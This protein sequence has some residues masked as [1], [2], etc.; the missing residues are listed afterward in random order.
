MQGAKCFFAPVSIPHAKS[1]EVKSFFLELFSP[2]DSTSALGQRCANTP[3]RAVHLLHTGAGC[4]PLAGRPSYLE[5]MFPAFV[6]AL[7]PEIRSHG[8]KQRVS[9]PFLGRLWWTGGPEGF[10]LF[11]PWHRSCPSRVQVPRMVL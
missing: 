7:P 1:L 4:A 6:G 9:N 3:L 11:P 5:D 8:L 2:V 10:A